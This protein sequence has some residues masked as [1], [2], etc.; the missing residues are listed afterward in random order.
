MIT[1]LLVAHIA[2]LGYWLGSEL[3]INSTYRYVC[4]SND[5]AF[6]ERTRLMDHVMHV[7]QHVRY[8]LAL[9]ATIGLMLAA[10]VGYVPGGEL[11][12]LTAGVIG[13]AWLGFVEAVHR[14]RKMPVGRL[15]AAIDRASRYVLMALLIAVAFGLVGGAWPFP[16]WLRWKFALFAGTMACG[17]G[18]RIALIAH[19]KTWEEMSKSGVTPERNAIIRTTYMRATA[20]LV[21]LWLFIG[22][23]VWLSVAKPV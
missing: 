20:I 4:F 17:V 18:I 12:A 5:M 16:E 9:Q 10:A 19:F 2:V 22:G 23:I 11:V 14:F 15:L 1:W 7:D 8:A 6:S 3:V 13:V 21:L